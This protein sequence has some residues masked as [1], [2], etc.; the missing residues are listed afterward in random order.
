MF[1]ADFRFHLLGRS[2]PHYWWFTLH[3][4][5]WPSTNN[6]RQIRLSRTYLEDCCHLPVQWLLHNWW[7]PAAALST[8]TPALTSSAVT[9]L[10][11]LLS[12]HL[13][14]KN[15][16]KLLSLAG[17][18]PPSLLLVPLCTATIALVHSPPPLLVVEHYSPPRRPSLVLLLPASHSF[19]DKFSNLV[20][21]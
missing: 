12:D 18:V 20:I 2:L 8:T 11:L 5:F 13:Y 10:T 7:C 21:R 6:S 19:A 9:C 1:E 14:G 16:T 4:H 3:P 17:V 15:Q